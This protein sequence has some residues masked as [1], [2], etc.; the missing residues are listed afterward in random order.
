MA[1]RHQLVMLLHWICTLAMFVATQISGKGR[2]GVNAV[3]ATAVQ[4]VAVDLTGFW[5]YNESDLSKYEDFDHSRFL[6]ELP[7]VQIEEPNTGT[8]T[9][10]PWL[11]LKPPSP[12]TPPPRLTSFDL[13]VFDHSQI[14]NVSTQLGDTAFLNCRIKNL[15][16]HSE[17][18]WVRRR[19]WHILSSGL[20]TFTN[21]ERF[22]VLHSE[23][24]DNWDLQIKF[25]QKRDNG[26]YECQVATGKG[27]MSHYYNLH[28]VIPSACIIGSG[29]YHIGEG[30][31]ISLI[32]I[33]ENSPT[34]P[35]YVFWYHNERMIN[36]DTVRG[37]VTV[38]TEPG[39]KTHSRLVVT[40]A[41]PSDS[42]NYT[43]RAPNTEED[44]IYVFVSK[45]G[46]NTAAI[47]RQASSKTSGQSWLPPCV[48]FACL[49]FW[50]C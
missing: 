40:K 28:V 14:T 21:D 47:Q 12:R 36:Y 33:I 10:A 48:L 8:T 23:H 37:G 24:S 19:D 39:T 5:S 25:V 16:E 6:E 15:A 11:P 26:T 31:T 20:T 18:S 38:S 7:G 45:E 41:T 32:C 30:S 13:P 27:T 3:N 1:R 35:Q 17:V 29:E 49:T 44:T 50:L 34:P 4:G 9:R 42:G 46:D 22:Q 43:C 2:G